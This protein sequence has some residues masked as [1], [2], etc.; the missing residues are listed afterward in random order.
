[1]KLFIAALILILITGCGTKTGTGLTTKGNVTLASQSFSASAAFLAVSPRW[2]TTPVDSF[3]FCVE[4]IKLE[5][6]SDQV[7]EKDGQQEIEFHPGLIDV[8]S[9]QE[10]TW[11]TAEIPV[12]FTLKRIK[13]DVKKE[14]DLCGGA[15]Y[16]VQFN[17]FQSQ[18]G[19][20][21]KWLFIPPIEV[22]AGDTLK[23]ALSEIVTTLKQAA[24]DGALNDENLKSYIE[25][26]E[27]SA[28][29]ED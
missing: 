11:G 17:G 1:M 14:N 9:G 13:V 23:L 15:D 26:T 8:S 7:V 3:K 21:F 20:E 12:S 29:H 19:I 16:S 25:S 24:G 2:I 27:G 18:E 28:E 10:K 22:K 5:N 6:E 4:K